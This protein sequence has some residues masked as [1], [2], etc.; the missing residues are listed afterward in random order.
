[1]EHAAVTASQAVVDQ[2]QTDSSTFDG[3]QEQLEKLKRASS[4]SSAW[5][6]PSLSRW[7]QSATPVRQS[8][9]AADS[10]RE[11]LPR[12]SLESDIK[13]STELDGRD[14]LNTDVNESDSSSIDMSP[15]PRAAVS[16]F[17]ELRGDLK[18]LQADI[19]DLNDGSDSSPGSSGSESET[20]ILSEQR[21]NHTRN[22]VR[23]ETGAGSDGP[24][25]LRTNNGDTANLSNGSSAH[26]RSSLD[27]D[28][29]DRARAEIAVS[30]KRNKLSSSRFI[31]CFHNGPGRECSGTD[32]SISEVLKKLSE[33]HETHVCD[34]CWV[35]KTK[36]ESSGRFVHPKDNHACLDHCL[37]PQ[38]H[39]SSST[40]GH[41]HLFDQNTCGT[42][43]SRVRPGDSEAVYRFI[44]RL[45]HPELDCPASVLTTEH[46]LH[47]DAVPRQ[48]RR[49]LNREELTARANDLGRRLEIGEQE[50]AVNV[51]RI[52]HLEQELA[53]A[54][55]ATA[56]AEEKYAQLE[57][58][59]RRIVAMLSDA[60]RTG[61]FL[62]SQDHQ[63]LLR[64]VEEDAPGALIHQSKP[65]LTPSASDRS[66]NSS[67][68]PVR[69]DMAEPDPFSHPV[70]REG[71]N[72]VAP[73]QAISGNH[74]T[75]GNMSDPWSNE[76]NMD[77]LWGDI[78]DEPGDSDITS[79][80]PH[81]SDRW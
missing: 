56:R 11:M 44:F 71:S 57:K 27:G 34:R 61:V 73:L 13:S 70:A 31:C 29:E 14:T 77:R 12:E 69:G 58:Q 16:V 75:D 4:G 20:L 33:Q 19:E 51:L 22:N 48:S 38:C 63:S 80:E 81:R 42:K 52:T 7:Y 39:K 24:Q 62:D 53:N 35:L 46:S 9:V 18:Q 15:V 45:V 74:T 2:P 25:D 79:S 43:T 78:F 26:K 23:E 65:L 54:H 10:A 17:A 1:M 8:E 47:L 66:R 5:Q 37:S 28:K 21:S 32:D 40:I 49:K 59:T 76:P 50:N 68:T 41:R 60:L 36:D 55:L 67:A 3:S 6:Q 72:Y 64:R 30:R